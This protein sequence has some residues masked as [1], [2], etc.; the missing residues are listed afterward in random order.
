MLVINSSLEE[1]PGADLAGREAIL[2]YLFNKKLIGTYRSYSAYEQQG[3]DWIEEKLRPA[4]EEMLK[5]WRTLAQ[6]HMVP[7]HFR[8]GRLS[9]EGHNNI[10]IYF[11]KFVL[12]AQTLAKR[13]RSAMSRAERYEQMQSALDEFVDRMVLQAGDVHYHGGL[14]PDAVDFRVF[15]MINRIGHTN[16][17]MK[18]LNEREDRT[19]IN[20]YSRMKRLCEPKLSFQ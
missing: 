7:K 16:V 2:S 11:F 9:I 14:A 10:K 17:M 5:D 3:L 8:Q 4:T 13:G 6:F 20:W 1:M 12:F 19:L 18:V 15:S